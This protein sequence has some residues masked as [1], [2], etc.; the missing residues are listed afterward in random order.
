VWL[1]VHRSN[2]QV[3]VQVEDDGPGIPAEH[4]TRVFDRFYRADA[5]RDREDGGS[6]LGLAIAVAI[7]EAHGG[8][9]SVANAPHG[10]AVFGVTLPSAVSAANPSGDAVAGPFG[11]AARGRASQPM[12]GEPARTSLTGGDLAPTPSRPTSAAQEA[13]DGSEHTRPGGKRASFS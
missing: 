9:I 2:D 7:V 6:G 10:G 5:A 12:R 11:T 4:L 8:A 13:C 1:T 3:I